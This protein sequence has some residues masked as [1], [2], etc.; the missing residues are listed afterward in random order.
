MSLF[1]HHHN[2]LERPEFAASFEV[3]G[4]DGV[5]R[6]YARQ[7]FDQIFSTTDLEEVRRQVGLGWVVLD[8]RQV[9]MAGRGPSGEDVISSIEGFGGVP[10]HQAATSLTS[11]VVGYLKDDVRSQ[12]LE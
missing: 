9:E 4:D 7:D 3:L 5:V 6:R 11:Y 10:G 2:D 12:P 8:E 1:H